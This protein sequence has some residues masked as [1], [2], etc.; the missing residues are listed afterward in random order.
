MTKGNHRHS[1]RRRREQRVRRE[2]RRRGG[3]KQG[4]AWAAKQAARRAKRH[5]RKGSVRGSIFFKG[6]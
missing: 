6:A 3:P 1:G 4:H 5:Y 2:L